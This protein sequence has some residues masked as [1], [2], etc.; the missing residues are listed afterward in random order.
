MDDPT[1]LTLTL[2]EPVTP[3]VRRY[4]AERPDGYTFSPGQATDVAI[5]ADGWRDETR[6]FTFTSLPEDP[7]LEFTIKSYPDHDGM[8]ERLA[9]VQVGDRL[10][11]AQPWGAITDQGPGVFIA[12]GAG[13]T[14]FL[15]ILR[16]R[17]QE[18]SLDGCHLI[19]SNSTEADII[20]RDELASMPGLRTTFVVT[21]EPGSPLSGPKLSRESL[22][23]LLADESEGPSRAYLCG[24]P[25][26][27]DD[28]REA[29]DSLGVEEIITEDLG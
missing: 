15:S 4:V 5:D 19:F 20:H 6:P 8:T 2:V 7:A 28:L 27:M 9:E 21:D 10:L 11:I 23:R 12:G 29:L 22:G 3:D 14:P 18:G 25:P 1:P 17:R 24:P 26:M 13:V 16:A